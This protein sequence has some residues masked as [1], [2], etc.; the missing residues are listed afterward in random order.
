MAS[1]KIA[2][3]GSVR[4]GEPYRTEELGL[5]EGMPATA[6]VKSTSVMVQS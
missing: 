1:A 5:R 3:N 4:S 2:L 6:I